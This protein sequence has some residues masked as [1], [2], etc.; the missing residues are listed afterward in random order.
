LLKNLL[1]A[2]I[3]AIFLVGC[4]QHVPLPQVNASDPVWGLVPDHLP[5]GELPQ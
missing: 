2:A 3:T 1:L 4:A 5:N